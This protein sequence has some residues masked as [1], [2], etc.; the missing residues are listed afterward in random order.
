M[1]IAQLLFGQIVAAGVEIVGLS[2]GA[3]DD[4][5]TWT[6]QPTSLQAAAQP[7]IDSFDIPAEETAWQWYEVRT[8][9]DQLLTISDWTQGNDTPL[10]TSEVTAWSTYRETLRNIPQ[11]QSD[12]YAIVWPTPPFV[13]NPPPV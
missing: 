2:I 1:D 4:K 8:Q 5:S 11:D 10:D 7:T 9:R 3:S 12:P 13:I 6:V